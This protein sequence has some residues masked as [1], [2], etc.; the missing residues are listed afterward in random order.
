ATCLPYT[1]GCTQSMPK[2]ADKRAQARRI[3]RVQRAHQLGPQHA[4]VRRVP[5][6]RGRAQPAGPLAA[7]KNY[8]WATTLFVLTLVG[9]AVVFAS[10]QHMGP[11][12][13]AR[14]TASSATAQATCNVSN[15]TCNKAPVMTIDTAKTYTATIHTAKGDIVI[16]LDAKNAPVA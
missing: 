3:A 12:A 9:L 14:P 10:S 11:W 16:E 15:H 8:P 7:I 4:V 5:A 1:R 6:A 13:R 2:T